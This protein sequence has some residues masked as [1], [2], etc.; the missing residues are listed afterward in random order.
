MKKINPMACF[1]IFVLLNLAEKVSNFVEPS[2]H[3]EDLFLYLSYYYQ[4]VV[5]KGCPSNAFTAIFSL[6]KMTIHLS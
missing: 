3:L 5:Y 4:E 1:T 2:L 6:L